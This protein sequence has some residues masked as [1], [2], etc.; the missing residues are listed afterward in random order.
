MG[1]P[2]YKAKSESEIGVN[3]LQLLL[4]TCDASFDLLFICLEWL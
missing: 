2:N 1:R 3:F 4:H